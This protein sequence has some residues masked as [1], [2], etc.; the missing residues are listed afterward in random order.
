MGSPSTVRPIASAKSQQVWTGTGM[1]VVRGT[2]SDGL[3]N[4]VIRRCGP[5]SALHNRW[6]L[7]W[8]APPAMGVIPCIEN[9]T[10][11]YYKHI[12]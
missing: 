4:Q 3:I 1:A 6:A 7:T 10:I 11:L 8:M 5:F 2:V 12:Q 9:E